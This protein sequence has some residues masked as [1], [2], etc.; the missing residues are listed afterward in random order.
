MQPNNTTVVRTNESLLATNIVLRN[1][2]LLLSLTLIFSAL[3]AAFAMA[4]NASSPNIFVFLI[5]AYGLMFLTTYLRNSSWGL[6]S[7]FAFTGFMGYTLGPI[8]NQFVSMNGT[9]IIVNA[10]GGTGLIFLA[11]SGY[12]MVSR[13]DFS[14]LGGFLFIGFW[15]LLAAMVAGIFFH[16]PAL[17]LAI[18]AGFIIFSSAAILFQ[19]SQIIEGGESNYILATISLYA[20]I[21]NI[22]VS[23]L[24]ILSNNRE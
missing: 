15:V 20:S 13:K 22:F 10:L 6:L 8:L 4:T 9:Q 11:L 17:H 24:S 5:G 3:C 7:V 18:S 23:L 1:T 14:F 21:Y 12:V 2:Y 16:V 19:T